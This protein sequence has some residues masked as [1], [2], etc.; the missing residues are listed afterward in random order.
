MIRRPPR[1]TLSSSSAASDV[2]KRQIQSFLVLLELNWLFDLGFDTAQLASM[3]LVMWLLA[4]ISMAI[5]MLISNFARNEGQ[6]FPFIPL[7]ILSAILSGIIVPLD[8]LP[9]WA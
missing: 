6:V 8:K 5:G 4:V 2:Y 1:S 9:E 3:Y 7:V